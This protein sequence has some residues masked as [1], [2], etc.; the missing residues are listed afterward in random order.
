LNR[1]TTRPTSKLSRNKRKKKRTC[2]ARSKPR[3]NARE[4]SPHNARKNSKTKKLP[5]WPKS[6]RKPRHAAALRKSLN[7]NRE[8]MLWPRPRD[9]DLQP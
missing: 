9:K 8:K 4:T 6:K 3:P 5:S 1:V 2:V 7:A